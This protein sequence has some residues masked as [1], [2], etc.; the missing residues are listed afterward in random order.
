MCP[1]IG[2]K[3]VGASLLLSHSFGHHKLNDLPTNK[4]ISTPIFY[5]ISNSFSIGQ[6]TLSVVLEY[7]VLEQLCFYVREFPF[8][9]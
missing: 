1:L 5:Y 4:V 7:R 3:K 8:L 2:P 6:G 9:Y